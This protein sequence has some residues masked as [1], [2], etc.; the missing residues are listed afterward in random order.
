M[1][2]AKVK[3]GLLTPESQ[4]EFFRIYEKVFSS[5]REVET[6]YG[7]FIT[8]GWISGAWKDGELIGILAWAPRE[9]ANNG[10]AEIVDLWVKAE[11]RR[12][13]TGGKL[14]EDAIVRMRRYYK[15]FGAV[16]S[17]VML[18]TGASGNFLAARKLY[19]KKGFRVVATI[20]KDALDN[21]YG[22]DFLCA[23][24]LS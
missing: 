24:Q 17:K 11:E 22:N 3:I 8:N 5:R 15:R 21:P 16:L 13:G 9:A 19:E 18:F 12:K 10:L 6:F 7:R 4:E 1:G 20:P 23:L 2:A 14:I